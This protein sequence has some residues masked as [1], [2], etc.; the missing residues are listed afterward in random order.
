MNDLKRILYE[1]YGEE[2][3]YILRQ[4]RERV[5]EGDNPDDILEE[6][7]LEPDYVYDLLELF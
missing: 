7:G 5:D 2:A 4:M 6:E 1:K 3:E